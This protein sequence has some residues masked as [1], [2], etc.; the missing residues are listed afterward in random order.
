METYF[1]TIR[2]KHGTKCVP[3]FFYREIGKVWL[4]KIVVE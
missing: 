4:G 3:L 2:V 1:G